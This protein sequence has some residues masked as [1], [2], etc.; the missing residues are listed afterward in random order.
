M[1]KNLFFVFPGS[2]G[3]IVSPQM[4]GYADMWTIRMWGIMRFMDMGL[5]GIM[6]KCRSYK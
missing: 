5:Y 2:S 4:R 6:T 3:R 1:Q